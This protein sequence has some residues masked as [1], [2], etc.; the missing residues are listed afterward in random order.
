MFLWFVETYAKGY[1]LKL[2]A[3]IL[4]R[5][6]NIVPGFKPAVVHHPKITIWPVPN[7][8]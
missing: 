4:P 3:T 2:F 5:I 7:G 1:I 6:L 8:L